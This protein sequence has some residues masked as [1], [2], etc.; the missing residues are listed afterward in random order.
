MEHEG[1]EIKGV[2]YIGYEALAG[3]GHDVPPDAAAPALIEFFR[4]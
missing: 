4:G 2:E 1:R 3:Q